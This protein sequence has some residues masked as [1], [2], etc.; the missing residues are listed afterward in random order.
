[1][2]YTQRRKTMMF[3]VIAY[4]HNDGNTISEIAKKLRIDEHEVRINV[5]WFMQHGFGE[6]Q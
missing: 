3:D 6:E 1:M 4:L 5:L 2:K